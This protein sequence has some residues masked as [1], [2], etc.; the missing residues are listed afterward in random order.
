MRFVGLLQIVVDFREASRTS[1]SEVDV[2]NVE[3]CGA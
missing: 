3:E 1:Q 2:Q